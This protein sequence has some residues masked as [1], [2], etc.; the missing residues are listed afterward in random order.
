MV[1]VNYDLRYVAFLDL[2][3]FK[4]MVSQST[5]DAVILNTINQALDYTGYIQHD[6]YNGIIPMVELG[7]QVTAFSDSVVISYDASM[8]GAGFHVLMDLVYIC[9]NLL[10]LGIPVRGGVTVGQLIHTERKCFGPAM[11]EAYLMESE[12]A[13]FPRVIV[14]SNLIKYALN[15]PG[16]ANTFEQEEKY[17][18][19]L[20]R[21]DSSDK[22]VILDYLKQINEFDDYEIYHGHILR[23]KE[24]I[25]KNLSI[26]KYTGTDRIYEK[27]VWLKKYYNE[28]IR[29]VYSSPEQLLIP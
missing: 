26:Y 11:V 25:T 17:L 10:G 19:E 24:F 9:N 15:N 4:N 22:I 7:K 13:K 23:T 20:L 1:N 28:T 16:R 14:D 3:G 2:M 12:K 27:Y 21:E 8:P 6:N 5:K 18:D 29:A